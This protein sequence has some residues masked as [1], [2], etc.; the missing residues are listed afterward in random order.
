MP[1]AADQSISLLS[2]ITAP[3]SDEAGALLSASRCAPG[4]RLQIWQCTAAAQ[5]CVSVLDLVHA[6]CQQ[7]GLATRHGGCLTATLTRRRSTCQACGVGLFAGRQAQE[8]QLN[9]TLALL[10]KLAVDGRASAV[11]RAALLSLGTSVLDMPAA[12]LAAHKADVLKCLNIA[13]DDRKRDVRQAAVQ[14]RQAWTIV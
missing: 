5:R 11:R 8:A 12:R 2:I 13:V 4:P 6:V 14:C 7:Q 1:E 9:E 3:L 10:L